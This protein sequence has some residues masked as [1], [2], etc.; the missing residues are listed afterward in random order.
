MAIAQSRDGYIWI[1]T[2]TVLIRF[3][4]VSFVDRTPPFAADPSAREVYNLLAASDGTLWIATDAQLAYWRNGRATIVSA[5][6][7]IGWINQM[8]EDK[9]HRIWFA[10]TCPRKTQ[11]V[12]TGVLS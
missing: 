3:D 4:G 5:P 12:K 6:G 8:L 11:P 10:V 9:E 7:G 1:G 2:E